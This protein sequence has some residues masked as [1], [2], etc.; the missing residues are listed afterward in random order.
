MGF[1]SVASGG[2]VEVW[3]FEAVLCDA[4]MR[5]R[6]GTECSVWRVG[7]WCPVE[8]GKRA[9]SGLCVRKHA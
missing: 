5:L 8:N 1:E 9:A 7:S 3:P 4:E 2:G 6:L